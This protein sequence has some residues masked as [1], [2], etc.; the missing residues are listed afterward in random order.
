VRNKFRC[1]KL[2]IKI[3][4]KFILLNHHFYFIYPFTNR[5]HSLMK[6]AQPLPEL[7]EGFTISTDKARLDIEVIHGYLSRSYWAKNIPMATV[8]QSLE[9]SLCFGVYYHHQQV[10]FARIVSDFATMAY[11]CDVFVLEDYRGRGL[12]KQLMAA[13]K[14]HSQLQGLRRWLLGT[15]DA[16]GLY[17]QFGFVPLDN[18]ERSMEIKVPD[19]YG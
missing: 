15:A 9:H 17:A 18:P 1:L 7:P 12:S 19:I 5:I 13:V 10:G 4:C 16:H 3:K 14:A 11:L 6:A 8:R 2:I